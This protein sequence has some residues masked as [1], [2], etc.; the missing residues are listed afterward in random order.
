[1]EQFDSSKAKI[2]KYVN[3]HAAFYIFFGIAF[4]IMGLMYLF[5]KSG[6]CAGS[7]LGLGLGNICDMYLGKRLFH[8]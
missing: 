6:F 3:K 7:L 1:M 5:G 4:I 8:R 2:D